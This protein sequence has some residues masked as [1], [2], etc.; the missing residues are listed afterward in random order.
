MPPFRLVP[1]LTILSLFCIAFTGCRS[2]AVQEGDE[3]A[4]EVDGDS[5]PRLY[6]QAVH[7]LVDGNDVGTAP[8]TVRVRRSFGTRE[9]T[10]W[11]AGDEIRT[12]EIEMVH[13]S[14]GIQTQQ[15]FWS[16]PSSDGASYDV[17]NLPTSGESTFLVPY[18]AYPIK[19]EDQAYGVTLL[20]TE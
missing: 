13:T 14:D 20:V 17:R 19:V 11:Q 2:S 5:G 7:V 8:M 15:G 18:S 12:Y 6:T 9:V 1:L 4:E 3:A 10:L 16:T